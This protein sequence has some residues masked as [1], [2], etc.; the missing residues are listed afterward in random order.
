MLY[1]RV[2]RLHFINLVTL[3]IVGQFEIVWNVAVS[4]AGCVAADR[5]KLG[6]RG[7]PKCYYLTKQHYVFFMYIGGLKLEI[8]YTIC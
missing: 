7:R 5:R 8:F 4:D 1:S 3:G 2:D 6:F